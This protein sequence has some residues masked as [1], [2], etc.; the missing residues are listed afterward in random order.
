MITLG[1]LG[2]GVLGGLA[3]YGT[4]DREG[5][6]IGGFLLGQ[7]V[8]YMGSIVASQYADLNRG[9]LAWISMGTTMGSLLGGGIGYH[10]SQTMPRPPRLAPLLADFHLTALHAFTV[11]HFDL[12]PNAIDLA[13]YSTLVGTTLGGSVALISDTDFLPNAMIGGSTGFLAGLVYDHLKPMKVRDT[14]LAASAALAGATVGTSLA[15]ML[16]D[17]PS[18]ATA[19]ALIG[20]GTAIG[21]GTMLWAAPKL[22]FKN[23][24]TLAILGSVAIGSFVGGSLPGLIYGTEEE[25]LQTAGGVGLGAALGYGAGLAISQ[26]SDQ[27]SSD[28]T[29]TLFM[30]SMGGLF[31]QGLTA[32]TGEGATRANRTL[33]LQELDSAW[34]LALLQRCDQ[35]PARG[36]LADL[37]FIG[38]WSL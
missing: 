20:A 34:V 15:F 7:G 14:T 38:L 4:S 35:L 3:A 32:F 23:G 31:G 8:G 21:Y 36:L 1:T 12:T 9:E 26:F 11:E 18:A 27:D 33:T 5:A 29:E 24:D 30:T 2:S 37:V 13:L 25:F 22:Q 16:P 10:I 6:S 19:G 28:I 17:E